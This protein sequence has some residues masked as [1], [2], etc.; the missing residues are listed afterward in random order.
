MARRFTPCHEPACG[1]GGGVR[2]VA[3]VA[4]RPVGSASGRRRRAGARFRTSGH[5]ARPRPVSRGAGGDMQEPQG[6]WRGAVPAVGCRRP[7]RTM[8]APIEGGRR[9]PGRCPGAERVRRGVR[10]WSITVDCV[11]NATSRIE[12][13]HCGHTSGS[14]SKI[15]CSNAN[16][17][18][19]CLTMTPNPSI[20]RDR[21]SAAPH[22]KR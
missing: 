16:E 17:P 19:V 7:P 15:S 1:P 20:E 12:P 6:A 3:C 21:L 13:A 11:M 14:T 2:P 9:A 5:T 4:G 22:V 8:D 10:I 18:K